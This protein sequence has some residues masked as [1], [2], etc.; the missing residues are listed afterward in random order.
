VGGALAQTV[1][2]RDDHL[3]FRVERERTT[4]ISGAVVESA[5]WQRVK[6]EDVHPPKPGDCC[7]SGPRRPGLDLAHLNSSSVCEG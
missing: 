1:R 4:E 2:T 5:A 6:Q 7:L 3:D